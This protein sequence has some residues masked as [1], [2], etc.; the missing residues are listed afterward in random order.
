MY[1]IA[2]THLPHVMGLYEHS[3]YSQ[4]WLYDRF[5]S[6]VQAG[7][8]MKALQSQDHLILDYTATG[9]DPVLVC[10]PEVVHTPLVKL[11]HVLCFSHQSCERAK[12][13]LLNVRYGPSVN[14]KVFGKPHIREA[15]QCSCSYSNIDLT[16]VIFSCS[17]EARSIDH[18]THTHMH[19]HTLKHY[20]A[21]Y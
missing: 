8:D 14:G 18:H 15:H 21:L 10:I 12:S 5:T 1:F 17:A 20:T 16:L 7:V 6:C 13:H 9:T 4:I 11:Y 19:A 3:R 2:F